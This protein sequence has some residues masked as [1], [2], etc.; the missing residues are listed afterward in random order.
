MHL[1]PIREQQRRDELKAMALV[2]T[3]GTLVAV[4]ALV[5]VYLIIHVAPPLMRMLAVS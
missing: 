1:D 2:L 3:A 5:A 4:G